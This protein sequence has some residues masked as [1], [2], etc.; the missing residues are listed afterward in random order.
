[1]LIEISRRGR[2]EA[3]KVEIHF[4]VFWISAKAKSKGKDF[5]NP[6]AGEYPLFQSPME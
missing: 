4:A 6:V 3:A 2:A 5:L 1:M